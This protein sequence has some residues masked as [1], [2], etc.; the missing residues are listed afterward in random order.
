MKVFINIH[1]KNK[2]LEDT[3]RAVHQKHKNRPSP[4]QFIDPEKPMAMSPQQVTP[5][6]D[7]RGALLQDFKPQEHRFH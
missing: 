2:S 6:T 1:M 4:L 5:K 7:A 3:I